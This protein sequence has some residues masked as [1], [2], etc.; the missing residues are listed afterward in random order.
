MRLCVDRN[1]YIYICMHTH[2]N[3]HPHIPAHT[4]TH[5]QFVPVV[6]KEEWCVRWG[7]DAHMLMYVCVCVCVCVFVCV[8]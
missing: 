4:H 5:V 1:V 7:L 6:S 2:I 8:Y 3:A